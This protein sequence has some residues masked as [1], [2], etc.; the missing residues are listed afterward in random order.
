ML[1]TPRP[2][3]ERARVAVSA[4]ALF[5]VIAGPR[6]ARADALSVLGA[7][8]AGVAEVNARAA[9]ADDGMAAHLNPGGLGMG[10]GVRAEVSAMLGV[11]ALS[12]QGKA[13][14]LADP[15][16]V[17]IAFDATVPFE[18]RPRD[19]IRIGLAGYIP[20]ASALHLI[21][22]RSDEPLYPYYDN[23]TQRLVIVPAIAV[24]VSEA[25]AAGVAFNV[26]G[27]V[28][29]PATVQS[30]ASRSPEARLDLAARTAL[31]INAGIRFDLSPRAR[32]A[33][34]LRQRF[35][36][37]AAVDSTAAL[38]GT[39]LAISVA[40][41]SVLFD[42]TTIVAAT[43]LDLGRA[44]FE[45]DASYAVWSAYDGP[46]V[47]VRATLP[48]VD[49][50]S[51]LPSSPA[52]DVVSLRAAGSYRFD[53]GARSSV[54]LRAGLGF[55]PSMLKS[56]A[57]GRTNLLDG[58]KL[59]VGLGGSWVIRGALPFALRV[60]LGA[61]VQWVSPYAQQKR[62]CAAA[63]CPADTVSG[64]DAARPAEGITNAGYPRLEGKGAL[65]STAFGLGVD[66]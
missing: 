64:P 48:G 20:P 4:I 50:T 58:D 17:A 41:D 52:R 42:P 33:L 59:L 11:S 2:A 37:P 29:G 35:A 66:L 47:S 43:S 25:I 14:P 34:A 39:P 26:L 55:E 51:A 1:E 18:G 21:A 54:A 15:F 62:V 30:G 40:T 13:L 12:A 27:G 3:T 44:S 22:R 31:S 5:A 57:Q 49:L 10:R 23:R 45:I 28:S 9:R 7:G 32:F 16:G 56:S 65:F 8:P 46:W 53:L 60:S 38:A 36:A 24:R 63:P 61:G 6:V 19:R